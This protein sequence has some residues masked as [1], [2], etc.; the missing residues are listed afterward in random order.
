LFSYEFFICVNEVQIELFQI[1]P[2]QFEV[3]Q[4]RR[5]Q[6]KY[7]CSSGSGLDSIFCCLQALH[8][9]LARKGKV[10]LWYDDVIL[11]TVPITPTNNWDVTDINQTWS[12]G[13]IIFNFQ[14]LLHVSMNFR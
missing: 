13:H 12:L 4:E 14:P 9:I 2:K 7:S 11:F 8:D 10:R 3:Q 5:S 1:S 6:T